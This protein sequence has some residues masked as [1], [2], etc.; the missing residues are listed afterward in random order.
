MESKTLLKKEGFAI[1]SPELVL[2]VDIDFG[3]HAGLTAE[4]FPFQGSFFLA[5]GLKRR[6]VTIRSHAES[7]LIFVDPQGQTLSNSVI[8]AAISSRT[9]Q[10][11]LEMR[12]GQQLRWREDRFFLSWFLGLTQPTSAGSHIETQLSVRNPAASDPDEVLAENIAVAEREQEKNLRDKA[13]RSLRDFE[14]M[15]LPLLGL[16]VGVSF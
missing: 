6:I 9:Q 12:L 5:L 16:E 15:T 7:Q 3:P 1:K 11:L 10:T 4:V 2:P 14:R 13:Y 8:D